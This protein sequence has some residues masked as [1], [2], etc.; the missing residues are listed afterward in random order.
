MEHKLR[1]ALTLTWHDWA[2]FLQAWF[3]LLVVD[4]GLRRL[5]FPRVRKLVA[6]VRPRAQNGEAADAAAEIRRLEAL[7]DMAARNHVYPMTCLRQAL[8]VQWLLARRGIAADL[9]IGVRRD[10]GA[11]EAHAWVECAG[12]A[13][14]L[15][16][17]F[18]ALAAVER[19]R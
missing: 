15:E 16:M 3:L 18:A 7:V 13:A 5:P 8:T 19:N 1:A 4:L 10:A 6:L 9:R 12:Q 11:L 17:R 2:V 14:G